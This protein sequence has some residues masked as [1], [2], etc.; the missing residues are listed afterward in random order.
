MQLVVPK[1]VLKSGP[2]QQQEAAG[3]QAPKSRMVD[4]HEVP[5][6]SEYM[7][8][9]E[10]A[11][12]KIRSGELSKVVLSRT[13]E[14]TSASEVDPAAL[15]RNLVANHT[16]GY[17]FAV[18]FPQHTLVGA[19]PELL[20]SRKGN[21]VISNPL[22]GSAARSTDPEEDQRRAANLLF[23]EKDLREHAVVVEAV[24]QALRPYCRTMQVPDHPSLVQT[25]TMWHL[26]SEIRGEMLDPETTSLDLAFALH[27]TPAVC[28]TPT[29]AARAAIQDIE[30]FDR[31]FYTGMI[32]WCDASGDGEWIV[33][34]RCAEVKER[35]LRLFAG[36]GIVAGSRP[37][38]ELDETTAKFRTMLRAM[39]LDGG[40]EGL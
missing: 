24:V 23:S 26:S 4:I 12:Q 36:A 34:I 31:D 25:P 2:L 35:S 21:L 29:L 32:G 40:E 10:R 13:L 7:C 39:G 30:P 28:G 19:S 38:D 1:E 6:P 11:L 9:V 22:A 15:L 18:D 37:E 14:L 20:V 3:I 8:G 5:E 17:T 16:S 33:T 27:P